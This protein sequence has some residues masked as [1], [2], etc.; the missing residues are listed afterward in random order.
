MMTHIAI[1]SALLLL[2][3]AALAADTMPFVSQPI[4]LT[5]AQQAATD[6]IA[7]QIGWLII[8]NANLHAQIE[9]LQKQLKAKE[10]QTK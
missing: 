4:V 7:R 10:E 8:E 3:S 5:P 1:P 2:S 9:D 6:Q